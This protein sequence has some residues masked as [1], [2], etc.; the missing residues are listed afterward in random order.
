MNPHSMQNIQEIAHQIG[1]QKEVIILEQL[2]ELVRR[3]LLLLEMGPQLIV[4]H[5]NP[6]TGQPEFELRQKATFHLRE[7]IYVE[8]LEAENKELR[9]A[10]ALLKHPSVVRAGAPV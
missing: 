3:N 6:A 10:L 9:R 7:S 8:N 5:L 1:A 4:T 2:G